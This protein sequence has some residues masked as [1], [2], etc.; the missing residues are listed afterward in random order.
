MYTIK[1]KL[2]EFSWV[3]TDTSKLKYHTNLS[4]LFEPIKED[5]LNLKW[6]VSDLEFT[7][8]NCEKLPIN[9]EKDWFM[10]SSEEMKSICET[11]AQI[12]WGVFVGID[13][14]LELNPR[15]IEIPY[16]DGNANIWKSGNL[17]IENSKVEIIAWDSSYTIVKFTDQK[18]SDKFKEYFDEAIKLEDYN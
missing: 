14:D 5:I 13:K 15:K 9:H 18:M 2:L 8:W 1:N 12:I 6:L 16:A 17:Q 3:I 4:V 7:N 10:I 11:E